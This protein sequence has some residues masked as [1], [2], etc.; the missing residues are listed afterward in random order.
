[1]VGRDNN[2]LIGI[3]TD[4]LEQKPVYRTIPIDDLIR[5]EEVP[6]LRELK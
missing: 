2:G 4:H 6:N 1:M 5:P 3:I